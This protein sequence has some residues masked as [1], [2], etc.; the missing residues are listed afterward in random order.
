MHWSKVGR[1]LQGFAG[2]VCIIAVAG[3]SYKF[4]GTEFAGGRISGLLLNLADL[5]ILLSVV[6]L[7][8]RRR[9]IR[10]CAATTLVASLLALPMFLYFVLP[11]P[12]RKIFPGEYSV[13]A[14]ANFVW[15]APAIIGIC[16]L[17]FASLVSLSNLIDPPPRTRL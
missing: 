2:V 15:D 9:A 13:S 14:S 12:F 17:I 11:R 8:L 5:S 10:V 1:L 3:Y 4:E 16:A 7:I 6:A